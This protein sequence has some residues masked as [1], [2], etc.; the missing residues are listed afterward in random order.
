MSRSRVKI[1]FKPTYNILITT[2]LYIIYVGTFCSLNVALK[3]AKKNQKIEVSRIVEKKTCETLY[4]N[5]KLL[6]NNM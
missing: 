6:K 3:F 2:S 4:Q 5:S 1:F